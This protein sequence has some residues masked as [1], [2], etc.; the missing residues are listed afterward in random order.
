LY[1]DPQL[2]ALEEQLLANS[3]DVSAALARYQ[4][5][6]AS[7]DQ[8]RAVQYPTLT[9]SGNLQRNQQSQARPLRVLGPTSPDQY[10]SYTLGVDL[11]YEFDLWGRVSNQVAASNYALQGAQTDLESARLSLQAQL[12]DTYIALRGLDRDAALLTRTVDNYNKAL[13][14][15]NT[16]HNAGIASGLDV[17]RAQSQ[18]ESSRSQLQQ[19]GAQR[20]VLEHAIAALV[21]KSASS[22]ALE[23]QSIELTLP[24]VPLGVPSTL[25]QR[26]PDISGAQRRM[27]A[28]NASI[29]VAN[30]A[31]FPTVTLS[32]LAGY[33]TSDI[34]NFLRA[35]NLYWAIG[36]SLFLTLFD[37]GR[38]Q[39][40]IDRVQ[41]VLDE[42]AARYRSV[43]LGAFQQVED[44][45][46][47]LNRYR[48]ASES[49]QAA[50]IA[51]QK[52]LELATNRYREGSANYLEVVAAQSAALQSQRSAL[53]LSTRQR[54]A[55]VQLIKALGGGWSSDY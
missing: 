50:T 12:A 18:L 45:L 42:S 51:A 39:A 1:G 25:L 14:L 53:E 13:D 55:S 47:L 22:F 19:T 26:R 2:N 15:T 11:E 29:G 46:A 28:A 33:Q 8:V 44:N 35:P 20:A 40:E 54:R 7:T 23:P 10:G 49:E 17:A 21:G 48:A 9:A 38:R 36:P 30:A 27:V 4:Q 31:F 24:Q 5:A 52:A 41:A 3:P 16:R 32:A 37:A 43:V 6:R 34:D